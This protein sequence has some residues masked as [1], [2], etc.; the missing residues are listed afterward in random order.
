MRTAWIALLLALLVSNRAAA[1]SD[2]AE[3]TARKHFVAGEYQ[4]ALDIYVTLYAQTLHPTYIRNIGRCYQSMGKPDEAISAFHEYLSKAKN[5][6]PKQRADVDGFIREMED[7]K[8]R[9]KASAEVAQPLAPASATE[10][11]RAADRSAE[12]ASD[13]SAVEASLR[14]GATP[15]EGSSPLYTRWWFWTTIGAVAVGGV[16]T[17]LVLSSG[18]GTPGAATT[19]GTGTATFK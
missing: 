12:R 4:Q 6:D 15:N 18:S 16:V 13:S 11:P 5:L 17:A 9:R 2:D 8:R 3:L 1:Q 19:F 7:L 14:S 10:L